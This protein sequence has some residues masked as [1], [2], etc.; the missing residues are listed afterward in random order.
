MLSN[1]SIK[2]FL[3][4]KDIIINPWHE[5]MMGAARITLYLGNK[6]LIPDKTT[7]VDVKKIGCR[8]IKLLQLRRINHFLWN[9]IC[10]F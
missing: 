5:D 4:S 8:T 1:I 10:L 3:A 2:K 9:L 7:I 6:I